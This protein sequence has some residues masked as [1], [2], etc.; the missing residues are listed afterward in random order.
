MREDALLRHR[1]GLFTAPPRATLQMWTTNCYVLPRGVRQ[2]ETEMLIVDTDRA[3]QSPTHSSALADAA[4]QLLGCQTADEVYDVMADFMLVLEP[5]SIIIVNEVSPDLTSLVTR[6]VSG[7]NGTRLGRAVELI[8]FDV[9]GKC[10]PIVPEHRDQMLEATLSAI[11]GGFAKLAAYEIS[12]AAARAIASLL[13]LHDVFSIGIADKKVVLG[14]VQI[15]T[16]KSDVTLPVNTVEVFIRHCFSALS[17]IAQRSESEESA[18]VN[19]LILRHMGEGLALHELILDEAGEPYDYRYIDVNPAFEKLMQM[20]AENIVGRTARELWP[21][22]EPIWIAEYG[23]VA[24]TGVPSRFEGTSFSLGR[25]FSVTA[26]SPQPGQFVSV[27]FDITERI[28]KEAALR[29]SELLHR[30]ILAASPDTIATANPMGHILSGSQAGLDM[31]GY[32]TEAELIGQPITTLVAPADR[33][34]AAATFAQML[35]GEAMAPREYQGLRADASIFDIE[36]NGEVLRSADGAPEMVVL[37]VRD[38]TERKSAERVAT[39]AQ[40]RI[41]AVLNTAPLQIWA[42]NGESYDY[43]NK[44]YLEFTGLEFTQPVSPETWGSFVHP[45]DLLHAIR[46]RQKGWESKTE[47]DGQ[48]RLLGHDGQYR[49]FWCRAVPILNED[50]SLE[51]F[52]GYNIDVT[53]RKVLEN[54][55]QQRLVAL[56]QPRADAEGITFSDLFEVEQIQAIQDAFSAAMGVASI[57]VAPG[58]TPITR[59]SNYSRLCTDIIQ[60][61]EKGR[62]ACVASDSSIACSRDQGPVVRHC[63]SAGFWDAGAAIHAG[64][65]HVA[66]WLVAQARDVSQSDEELFAF[67][68]EIGADRDEFRSALAEIPVMTTAQFRR[69]ADAMHAVANQLSIVAYQNVQQAR[70]ITERAAIEDEL[71]R[72]E[73]K[74]RA[75]TESISDVVWI[76]DPNTLRYLYISPS[77]QTLR[78]FTP[79]ELLEVTIDAAL[80]PAEAANV[81]SVIEERTQ[82]FLSGE[83]PTDRLY[84]EE[85]EQSRKDGS[86]VWT[87]V[88]TTYRFNERTGRAEVHGVS[89]DITDRREAARLI[90]SGVEDL[91]RSNKDLQEFAYVASHDLRE[92]LRMVAS[93]TQLLQKRYQGQLDADADDFIGFAVE[94]VLRMQRLL[95]DLLE[96]SRAGTRQIA[97]EP[98]D[99]GIAAKQAVLNLNDAIRESE[100]TVVLGELPMVNAS[101]GQLMRV[102]QNLI[103]NAI[104][105]HAPEQKPRVEVLAVRVGELW[106]FTVAD[107]GIG[108]A[109]Q[110]ADRIFDVFQ[111]LHTREAYPGT[112]IGLSVCRRI[113]EGFGGSIWVEAFDEPGTAFKFTLPAAS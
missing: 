108:I 93:Y 24:T 84:V 64:G 103:A 110:G 48:M 50:G 59:P 83:Q 79:E 32:A 55:L 36:V 38:I 37:V 25:T 60:G 61:T 105:F 16:T 11:P 6:K 85:V 40:R 1:L 45:E 92:P 95:D 20:P 74:Y 70:F 97:P 51:R 91:E 5:N 111:R 19:S 69:I 94:G 68:D 90:L 30:S 53:E 9:L 99:S 12:P 22:I 23:Q 86:R 104:K 98:V 18:R 26:Y 89:R 44:A 71:R 109:S 113:V 67:A 13:S 47:Y 112:G 7:L 33:E 27:L 28:Q 66:N 82:A 41:E 43:V 102:F 76:L 39:D 88:V 4:M 2:T 42:F 29:A 107:N 10:F 14:N 3:L 75:I 15:Y 31:F 65:V 49:D 100:A 62:A 73:E 57:I 63:E 17:H 106:E 72:S 56:S 77:V 46:A 58:G 87:E 80:G 101:E 81:R 78:G 8:G 96:Y 34:R 54:A 52:L 35:Q 21:Q